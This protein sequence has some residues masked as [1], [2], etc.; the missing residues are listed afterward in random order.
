MKMTRHAT[1]RSQQRA[2]AANILELALDYGRELESFQ[3]RAFVFDDR[4]LRLAPVGVRRQADRLRGLC[5]ILTA[6]QSV[7]T[8]MWRRC[9][10]GVL[11]RQRL[12]EAA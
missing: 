2:I 4:S 8:V 12:L 11:R 9:K 5:V 10:P 7:R 3:D 6:D 1:R